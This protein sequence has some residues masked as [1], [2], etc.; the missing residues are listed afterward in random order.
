MHA[1]TW[2][3]NGVQDHR[4]EH[5]LQHWESKSMAY[6]N[7]ANEHLWEKGFPSQLDPGAQRRHAKVTLSWEEKVTQCLCVCTCYQ[8]PLDTVSVPCGDPSLSKDILTAKLFF[9][10]CLGVKIIFLSR[11][12]PN[13]RQPKYLAENS[14]KVM[15]VFGQIDE[16][17]WF[18][19]YQTMTWRALMQ[20]TCRHCGI[21]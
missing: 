9:V 18:K 16:K 12:A 10:I 4:R 3:L 6:F 13:V 11:D 17:Y 5:N 21:I 1:G 20:Q 19:L 14:K 15:S 2:S 8:I 7:E